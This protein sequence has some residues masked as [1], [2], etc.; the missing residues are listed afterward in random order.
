MMGRSWGG[1]SGAAH[2]DG[3]NDHD[4][5]EDNTNVSVTQ[6]GSLVCQSGRPKI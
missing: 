2:D 3:E 6:I 4:D 5:E 1:G